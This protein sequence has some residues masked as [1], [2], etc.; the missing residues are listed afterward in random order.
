VRHVFYPSMTSSDDGP[1]KVD[2]RTS[3]PLN[4]VAVTTIIACLLALINL[5]SSVILNNVFSL[6]IAGFYST[7][8]ASCSLLLWRRCTGAIRE[9]TGHDSDDTATID[10]QS[11]Q[12]IWGPWRVR[13]WLGTAINAFACVYLVV[14]VF[15]SFWPPSTPTTPATMNYSVLVVGIVLI[16][17]I[18]YYYVW[19]RF[20][21][22]GPI[23]EIVV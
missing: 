10:L 19:G 6:A 18:S 7:Y 8:F 20:Q 5:G 22:H 9:P 11:G 15:F 1:S 3:I 23:I 2:P 14:I 12:L 16:F 21:Y 17:S 13:G 4:A